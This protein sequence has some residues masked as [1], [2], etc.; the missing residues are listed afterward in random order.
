[1]NDFGYR[2]LL[3]HTENIFMTERSHQ[4]EGLFR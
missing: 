3:S 1:M 4:Q 2:L